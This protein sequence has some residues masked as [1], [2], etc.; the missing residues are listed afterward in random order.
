M[1]AEMRHCVKLKAECILSKSETADTSRWYAKKVLLVFH[2]LFTFS[3]SL[4]NGEASPSDFLAKFKYESTV[5][6]D[7][8]GFNK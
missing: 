1:K 4:Q 7:C 6:P 3:R 8:T 2:R 5:Y